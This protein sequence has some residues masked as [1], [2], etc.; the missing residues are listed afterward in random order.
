[1]GLDCGGPIEFLKETFDNRTAYHQLLV[2]RIGERP[3]V[4]GIVFLDP[5]TGLER[6]T[7][8][9]LQ[10][11]RESELRAVWNGMSEMACEERKLPRI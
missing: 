11:V 5:E 7:K 8:S 4:P 6:S 2:Q 1:V 10:H 9:G 3:R